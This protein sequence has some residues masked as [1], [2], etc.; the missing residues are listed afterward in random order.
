MVHV[1]VT[2][3][4]AVARG[5]SIDIGKSGIEAHSSLGIGERYHQPLRNTFRKAKIS[6]ATHIPNSSILAMS[7]KAMNDTLGPEGFVPSALVF[8]V[9][10]STQVFEDPKDPKPTLQE[11]AKLAA[12]I[13]AEMDQHMAKLRVMRALRHQVPPSSNSVFEVGESVLVFREKQVNNRIG[14]WLGPYVV[15]GID[16][17]R[18]LIYVQIKENETPKAFGLAQVKPYFT[19]TH[20]AHTFFASLRDALAQFSSIRDHTEE[21]QSTY[22]TEIVKPDDAR[23][24]CDEMIEAKKA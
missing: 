9:Y 6:M 24:N 1:S 14:E 10:P 4:L 21:K 5:A 7:V 8:G 2:V 12:T 17:D 20:A 16:R 18:K 22:S 3:F 11:R 23:A 19:P 13:R 15:K